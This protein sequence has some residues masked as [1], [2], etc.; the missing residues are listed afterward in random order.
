[1][2]QLTEE[3]RPCILG[4][5]GDVLPPFN[6]CLGVNARHVCIPAEGTIVTESSRLNSGMNASCYMQS[7]ACGYKSCTGLTHNLC[8]R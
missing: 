8:Q 5:F 6:V 2:P 4:S 3:D 1:M 7:Q